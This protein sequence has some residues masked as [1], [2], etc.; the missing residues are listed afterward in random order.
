VNCDEAV[1]AT[2]PTLHRSEQKKDGGK[3]IIGTMTPG[4]SGSF[5]NFCDS[6]T[7]PS[8]SKGA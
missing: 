4:Y 7:V 1:I 2:L 5:L 8:R 3:N 6:G